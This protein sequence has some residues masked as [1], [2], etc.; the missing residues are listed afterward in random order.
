MMSLKD[1]TT[2]AT[3]ITACLSLV[4]VVP[5]HYNISPDSIRSKVNTLNCSITDELLSKGYTALG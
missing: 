1:N 2:V 3:N 4:V 5:L